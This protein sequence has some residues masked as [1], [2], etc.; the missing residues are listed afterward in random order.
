MMFNSVAFAVDTVSRTGFDTTSWLPAMG[1]AFSGGDYSIAVHGDRLAIAET[2]KVKSFDELR[3]L[4][5]E[6][7]M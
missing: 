5:Q 1:W 3:R 7:R 6:A 4:P 2:E